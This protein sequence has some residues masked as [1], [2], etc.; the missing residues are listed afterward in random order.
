MRR[1]FA[2]P[3]LL[4]QATFTLPSDI[5]QHLKVLRI[6]AGERIELFDGCGLEATA[7][8]TSLD[9]SIAQ[10]SIEQ[11]R[12][13]PAPRLAFRLLQGVPKGSKMDLL[14]QKGTELGISRFSPVYCKHG[15][16]SIAPRRLTGRSDRWQKIIQEAA[17]QSGRSHLPRLDPPDQLTNLLPRVREELRLVPWEQGGEPLQDLLHAA[18]PQSIACLIGPEGGLTAAEVDLAKANGFR[19]VTLGPRILRSETAGIAVASILLYLFGD[20]GSSHQS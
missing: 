3:E 6:A 10:V 19:P 4:R 5:L 14:L 9:K 2:A 18:A 20:L 15:D 1:F 12:H 16:V 11:R 13:S 8:I 7:L 17:R